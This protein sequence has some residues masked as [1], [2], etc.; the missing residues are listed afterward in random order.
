VP[1]RAHRRRV[2]VGS[3]DVA[4]QER[5]A[6]EDE[7]RLLCPTPPISDGVCVMGGRV[8]RCRQRGHERVPELE[9]I[10]VG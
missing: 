4:D 3:A 7:P 9:Q 1:G 10:A 2:Q 8:S 5:V 6:A